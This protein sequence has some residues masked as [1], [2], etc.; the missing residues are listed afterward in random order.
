MSMTLDFYPMKKHRRP[1]DIKH[2]KSY[3]ISAATQINTVVC[4]ITDLMI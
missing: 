1:S 2:T 3:K 4:N